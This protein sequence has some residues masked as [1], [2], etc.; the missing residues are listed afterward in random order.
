[1]V[2]EASPCPGNSW[3]MCPKDKK[4]CSYEGV[5][6]STSG[7][8]GE[9]AI[10]QHMNT[11]WASC[12]LGTNLPAAPVVLKSR[13]SD[14]F[15]CCHKIPAIFPFW[16][17]CLPTLDREIGKFMVANQHIQQSLSL[18][19]F[20]QR[21]KTCDPLEAAPF[22]L[23]HCVSPCILQGE[24]SF[25]FKISDFDSLFQSIY[26]ALFWSGQCQL[27]SSKKSVR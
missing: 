6:G 26:E 11:V 1:M 17:P 27:A 20:C 13:C 10:L 15:S 8:W 25:T 16:F 2:S 5:S 21:W 14:V 18:H 19:A 12:W 23:T 9:K 7:R 3:A 24:L 4:N 22:F